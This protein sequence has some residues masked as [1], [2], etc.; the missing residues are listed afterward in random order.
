MSWPALAAE[1]APITDS[2]ERLRRQIH[3]NFFSDDGM[4]TSEVFKP[5]NKMVSTTRDLIISPEDAYERHLKPT[6]GSCFVTIAEVEDC[7]LR[8][9]DDSSVDGVPDGHAY[10]DLRIC[11]RSEMDRKAKKLKRL[12][13]ENGIWRP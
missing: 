8:A 5:R 4:I 9:I 12:A 3:P 6:I 13:M 7:E 11:G 10:I 1:E 2:A